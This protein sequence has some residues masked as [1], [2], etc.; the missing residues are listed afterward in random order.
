MQRALH[1]LE[2]WFCGF[3]GFWGLEGECALLDGNRSPPEDPDKLYVFPE[4]LLFKGEKMSQQDAQT[5]VQWACGSRLTAGGPGTNTVP[6][7]TFYFFCLV[8]LDCVHS[9]G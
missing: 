5:H 6:T 7:K 3:R 8:V 9:I 4:H 2:R 1:R